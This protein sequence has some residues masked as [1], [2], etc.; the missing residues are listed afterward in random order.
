[1]G[2]LVGV[3]LSAGIFAVP[4]YAIMQA[5]SAESERARVVAGNNI[6]NALFIV[7]AG[8]GSAVMLKLGSGVPAI[9][10]VLGVTNAALAGALALRRPALLRLRSRSH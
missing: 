6:L 7:V 10:L 3:A 9:F 4:L 2:D 8:G 5:R 1:V